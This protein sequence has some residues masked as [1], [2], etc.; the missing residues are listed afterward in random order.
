[1]SAEPICRRCGHE[2]CPFCPD[3]CDTLLRSEADGGFIP[4]DERNDD[5]T[6]DWPVMCCGGACDY[7]DDEQPLQITKVRVDGCDHER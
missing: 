4:D 5:G 6:P 2:R 1:M 7:G 3:W